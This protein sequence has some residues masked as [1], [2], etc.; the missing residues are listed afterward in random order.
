MNG[1]DDESDDQMNCKPNPTNLS[2][3]EEANNFPPGEVASL[4]H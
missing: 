1:A 2:K 3:E 4:I